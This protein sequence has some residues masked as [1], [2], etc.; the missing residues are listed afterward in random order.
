MCVCVCNLV[1]VQVWSYIPAV[2]HVQMQPLWF[3]ASSNPGRHSQATPPLGVS[4]QMWAQPCSLFIQL[5]PSG[6]ERG[7]EVHNETLLQWLTGY[8]QR[9]TY[10]EISLAS[11]TVIVLTPYTIEKTW[12]TVLFLALVERKRKFF[13]QS[14]SYLKVYSLKTKVSELFYHPQHTQ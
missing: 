8:T 7:R 4:L 10:W 2:K 12:T 6:I 13:K 3:L 9:H 5:R 14:K 1:G 11:K